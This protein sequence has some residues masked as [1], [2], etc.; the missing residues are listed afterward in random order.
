MRRL[1]ARGRSGSCSTPAAGTTT[2]GAST[3]W[4]G[5]SARA[6]S[7]TRV[8]SVPGGV[9]KRLELFPELRKRRN[10][11][12]GVLSGGEQQMLALGRALSTGPRVLLVDEMSLG[13]APVVVERLFSTLQEIAASSGLAVLMVEQHV[14]LA[15]KYAQHGYVLTGGRPRT[16]GTA[17]ELEERRPEIEA[18]YLGR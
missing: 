9:W 14:H 4:W 6:S 11:R 7:V 13:L 10:K 12:A 16:S 8:R 2:P 1:S 3:H 17:A 5:C 15:L 18:S